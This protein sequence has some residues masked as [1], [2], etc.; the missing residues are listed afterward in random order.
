MIVPPKNLIYILY[1]KYLIFIIQILICNYFVINFINN[2][3]LMLN[4]QKDYMQDDV[5]GHY[6]FEE[7][8]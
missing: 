5:V 6:F 7:V 4:Q 3:I 8:M 1:D 2:D